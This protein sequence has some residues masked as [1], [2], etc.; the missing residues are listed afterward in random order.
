V[1]DGL[2][3]VAGYAQLALL[4]GILLWLLLRKVDE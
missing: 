4:V 3:M 2:A 1:T